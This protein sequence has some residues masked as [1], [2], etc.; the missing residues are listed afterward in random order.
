MKL[1]GTFNKRKNG[2]YR[3]ERFKVDR[4]SN[5]GFIEIGCYV[6]NQTDLTNNQL[7]RKLNHSWKHINIG[8]DLGGLNL[9]I[10]LPDNLV[11]TFGYITLCLRF[12]LDGLGRKLDELV[13]EILEDKMFELI[14]QSPLD[15]IDK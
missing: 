2:N 14:E 7:L 3:I 12:E 4:D 5:V 10:E 9:T 1:I 13:W 6:V 8:F 15:I 11:N